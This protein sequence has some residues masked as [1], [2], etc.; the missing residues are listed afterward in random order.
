MRYRACRKRR[1]VAL[2]LEAGGQEYQLDDIYRPSADGLGN[3]F[4]LHILRLGGFGPNLLLTTVDVTQ[5]G[6]TSNR[7]SSSA[8]KVKLL[9][10]PKLAMTNEAAKL[11]SESPRP[12]SRSRAPLLSDR[13]IPAPGGVMVRGNHYRFA[14]ATSRLMRN[15]PTRRY[16]GFFEDDT[17]PL[18]KRSPGM[19]E[20]WFQLVG[21]MVMGV[22]NIPDDQPDHAVRAL[23]ATPDIPA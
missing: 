23:W 8:M 13:Q 15:L 10:R 7:C 6:A 18:A 20:A 22:F 17:S 2:Q 14:I 16:A 3:Y 12:S 11:Y 1:P 9:S 4:D 21:D 5:R 19:V